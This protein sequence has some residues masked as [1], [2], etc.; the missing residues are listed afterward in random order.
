MSLNESPNLEQSALRLPTLSMT[1]TADKLREALRLASNNVQNIIE[2]PWKSINS[3]VNYMIK[4]SCQVNAQEPAW[5]LHV[6]GEADD[7]ILWNYNTADCQMIHGL[8][9]AEVD[10][11]AYAAAGSAQSLP[12]GSPSIQNTQLSPPQFIEPAAAPPHVSKSVQQPP[13]SQSQNSAYD[14]GSGQSA[15]QQGQDWNWSS[16]SAVANANWSTSSHSPLAM[17]PEPIVPI[18]DP[19]AF[20]QSWGAPSPAISAPDSGLQRT[21]KPPG[22]VAPEVK[23]AESSIFL[24]GPLAQGNYQGGKNPASQTQGLPQMSSL[25]PLTPS[26]AAAPA[27]APAPTPVG[28]NPFAPIA[29]PVPEAPAQA[30]SI[31][32][33]A[34]VPLASN[35]GVLPSTPAENPSLPIGGFAHSTPFAMSTI[36]TVPPPATIDGALP[37]LATLEAVP[38]LDAAVAKDASAAQAAPVSDVGVSATVSSESVQPLPAVPS[39]KK[40]SSTLS[41]TLPLNVQETMTPDEEN[42][43]AP[44]PDAAD[45][46]PVPPAEVPPPL[47]EIPAT[48]PATKASNRRKG[49]GSKLNL[50]AIKTAAETADVI[51]QETVAGVSATPE[52]ASVAVVDLAAPDVVPEQSIVAS[53]SL[54]SMG[55][56]ALTHSISVPVN[57]PSVSAVAAVTPPFDPVSLFEAEPIPAPLPLAPLAPPAFTSPLSIDLSAIPPLPAIADFAAA[58]VAEPAAAP[59]AEPATPSLPPFSQ[60]P[61]PPPFVV[62]FD[63]ADT[64]GARQI[65]AREEDDELDPTVPLNVATGSDIENSRSLHEPPIAVADLAAAMEPS[66]SPLVSNQPVEP[67]PLTP[68]V[69]AISASAPVEQK[70]V[71]ESAPKRAL[72]PPAPFN[73]DAV[74]VIFK[75]LTNEETGFITN[76]AFMFFIVREFSRFQKAQTP[77]TLIGFELALRAPDGAMYPVHLAAL[78]ECGR[79]FFSV[80]RPLDWLAHYSDEEYALLLPHTN[81]REAILLVKDLYTVL[82]QGPLLPGMEDAQVVMHCGIASIPEDC[83]HPG[84]LIAAAYEAKNEAKRANLALQLFR[85][86]PA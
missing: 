81:I 86:M 14:W 2:L 36:P 27:S 67:S 10:R 82:N 20:S 6:G 69:S 39:G 29:A 55:E 61:L 57:A 38:V 46:L 11:A 50:P 1:P 41:A 42:L 12:V 63:P 33:S 30:A 59:V 75:H 8:I 62:E 79:R 17:P 35:T 76:S 5:I 52:P 22:S 34:S 66:P 9:T 84:I 60:P 68:E 16:P 43:T 78:R 40:F 70:P 3:P 28:Q 32:L 72:P 31:P 47:T 53:P 13:A 54:P 23:P 85:D 44:R 24:S 21:T 25:D 73:R 45:L 58:P 56:P 18:N 80:M 48:E 51:E 19:Q 64:A 71:T 37:G 83:Q 74:D 4:V 7:A 77:I 65:A 15:S 49:R 26:P